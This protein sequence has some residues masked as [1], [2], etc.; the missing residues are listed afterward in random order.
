M[1]NGAFQNCNKL[2]T[3]DLTSCNKL[4]SVLNFVFENC[5]ELADITMP[6]SITSIGNSTFQKCT[7]LTTFKLP[8]NLTSIGSYTFYN[9]TGLTKVTYKGTTYTSKRMLLNDLQSNNVEIT[10]SEPFGNTGL[11]A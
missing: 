3:V 6:D 9:C 2:T 4:K 8:S 5:T 1:A 11:G 10:G 7:G